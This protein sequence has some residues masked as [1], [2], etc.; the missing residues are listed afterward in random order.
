MR[1]TWKRYD[2]K[3]LDSCLSES[4]C[5]YVFYHP[6]DRRRPFYVG[7]ARHFGTR[8]PSGYKASARY[9]SGYLHLLAGMLR[10]GFRLYVARIGQ[11]A[12]ANVEK[13]E[14]ELIARWDPIRKQRIRG[15]RLAVETRKPWRLGQSRSTKKRGPNLQRSPNEDSS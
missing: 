8:Q 2:Y 4:F 6:N 7:K 11:K 10:A 13:Y 12:F 9:N 5:L 1:L 15:A 3:T 14:Q